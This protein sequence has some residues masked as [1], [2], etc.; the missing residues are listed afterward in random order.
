MKT[1]KKSR[2]IK[3]RIG[4]GAAIV[5]VAG[6]L[7]YSYSRSDYK[8]WVD[9]DK[10]CQ[11][12]REEVLIIESLQKPILDKKGCKVIQG[13]WYDPYTDKYFTNPNDLDVDHFVPLKEVD[14]SGGSEWNSEKKMNYA[15]DLEDS[16]T[17]IAVDKSANRAKGD[18]DPSDWLPTNQKYQCEYIKNWQEIKKKWNLKMDK[19]EADFLKEK[20]K[21]CIPKKLRGGE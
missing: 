9:A 1:I 14:R 13:K 2:S 15:N 11:N 4:K 3:S 8:H 7:I 6:S 18:K 21:E 12:T 10:D 19:K 16:K 5:A 17:L 20:N